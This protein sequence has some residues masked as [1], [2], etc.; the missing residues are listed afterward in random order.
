MTDRA[1]GIIA[2]LQAK[3]DST[4]H[5]GERVLLLAKVAELRAK[6]S[7]AEAPPVAEQVPYDDEGWRQT[8]RDARAA[9]YRQWYEA[10]QAEPHAHVFENLDYDHGHAC[11]RERCS[12]GEWAPLAADDAFRRAGEQADRAAEKMRRFAHAGCSHEATKTARARCRR[13]RGW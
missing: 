5:E 10:Q 13:E 4:T 3:A 11:F 12:C 8:V 6:Y 2:S 9:A 1:R 7:I